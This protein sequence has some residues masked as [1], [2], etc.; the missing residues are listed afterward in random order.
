MYNINIIAWEVGKT[1]VWGLFVTAF[2]VGL[3]GAMVPGPLLT[4]TIGESARHGLAAAPLIVAGH[5]VL[6]LLLVLALLTGLA[7]FLSHNV[8]Q[9][10]AVLGGAFM[11]YMGWGMIRDVNAG[12]ISADQVQGDSALEA[13]GR[14]SKTAELRR[15]RLSLW[16][17]L[18]LTGSFI[19]LANPYWVIWWATVGLGYLTMA[20]KTGTVGLA[21]FFSGHISA[22]IAWYFLVGFAV[23]GGRR[24]FSD[25]IY[26]GTLFIC[27]IFLLGLGLYFIYSGIR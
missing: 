5:I 13:T 14:T 2:I 22:D 20:Y 21:S 16:P 8:S 27:G 12:R 4:V 18:V 26:K 15:S 9:W 1:E 3:S 6:E 25:R 23:A 7:S 24:F 17:R 11:L 19:T 10:V